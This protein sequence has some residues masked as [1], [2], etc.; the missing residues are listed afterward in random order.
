LS[1]FQSAFLVL[2]KN[3]DCGLICG[4]SIL[5]YSSNESHFML[6]LC[7]FNCYSSVAY[8]EICDDNSNNFLKLFI[9]YLYFS[10]NVHSSPQIHL[11]PCH[12]ISLLFP[13]SCPPIKHSSKQ[14]K[15]TAIK[16]KHQSIENVLLYNL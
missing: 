1:V 8:R 5:I 3:R 10:H 15:T 4:L 2:V 13:C 14:M 12:F 11:C 16:T 7:C 6:V 9:F